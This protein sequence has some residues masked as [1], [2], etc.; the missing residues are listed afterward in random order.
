MPD[1][2]RMYAIMFRAAELAVRELQTTNNTQQAVFILKLAQ[3]ACE[4][5]YISDDENAR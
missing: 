2:K 5:I 1:Y 3:S 4:E